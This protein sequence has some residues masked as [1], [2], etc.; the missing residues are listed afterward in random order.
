M[1]NIWFTIYTGNIDEYNGIANYRTLLE[2]LMIPAIQDKI[3]KEK[4]AKKFMLMFS[5]KTE[6]D[7]LEDFRKLHNHKKPYDGIVNLYIATKNIDWNSLSEQEK[8]N[9][10]IEKWK[11]L[12]GNL[13]DDYF[14]V[15][16][17]EVIDSLEQLRKED[18]KHTSLLFKKKLK[19]NKESYSIV[20]DISVEK[21]KLALVREA[22]EKRFIL[23]EYDE[24]WRVMTDAIFKNFNLEGDIL[25][26]E[27][28]SLFLSPEQFDLKKLIKDL[29]N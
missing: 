29:E 3:N 4:K 26:L 20:L 13:S 2:I 23:K 21:A 27:N 14:L 18:W 11:V 15:D 1:R 17:S 24:V 12:F 22:D 19:Y 25:T 16:K 10:L 28:K 9:F 5:K 7:N 8:K 6:H